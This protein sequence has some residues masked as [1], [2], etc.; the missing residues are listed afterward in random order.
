MITLDDPRWKMMQGGY[1]VPYDPTPAL[2]KI[3]EG[4][5]VGPAWEE[6]WQELHHQGDLGEASYACIPYLVGIHEKN[7]RLDWNLFALAST[8][9]LVRHRESNPAIADWLIDS[10]EQAWKRLLALALKQLPRAKSTDEIREMLAA[11]A[12][13]KGDTKVGKILWSIEEGELDEIIADRR[14]G[15]KPTE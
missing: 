6:L 8:I 11:I 9:E 2:R 5:D 14:G 12:I 15:L 1:R 13:A 7:D 10:Y 3:E 4:N